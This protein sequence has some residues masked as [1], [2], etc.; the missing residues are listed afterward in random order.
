MRIM[1]TIE[2]IEVD[3]ST[4][5]RALA[6]RAAQEEELKRQKEMAEAEVERTRRAREAAEA[7]RVAA[8]AKAEEERRARWAAERARKAAEEAAW[9]AANV[10]LVAHQQQMEFLARAAQAEEDRKRRDS[11]ARTM[12]VK[13]QTSVRSAAMSVRSDTMSMRSDAPTITQDAFL[14]QSRHEAEDWEAASERYV[15]ERD[16]P[17]LPYEDEEEPE[18]DEIAAKFEESQSTWTDQLEQMKFKL[19]SEM[20]KFSEVSVN[21]SG[22]FSLDLFAE[23]GISDA[24][25][26]S[27]TPPTTSSNSVPVAHLRSINEW[28]DSTPPAE[29]SA[30]SG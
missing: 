23:F 16:Q 21:E 28:V 19:E 17:S 14:R 12:S 30:N 29:Q 7:R 22:S 15:A 3:R 26:P 25:P 1:V 10:G 18:T 24:R 9:Q 8:R 6:A 4:R 27:A 2:E 11:F 13:S 5:R 20:R